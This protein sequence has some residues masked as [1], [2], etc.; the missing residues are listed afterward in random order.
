MHNPTLETI[1]IDEFP[2]PVRNLVD[3]MEVKGNCE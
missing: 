1:E 3:R 2:K